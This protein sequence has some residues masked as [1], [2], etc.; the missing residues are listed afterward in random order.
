MV[1]SFSLYANTF[2]YLFPRCRVLTPLSFSL[3]KPPIFHLCAGKLNGGLGLC[4]FSGL[5]PLGGFF[6]GLSLKSTVRWG[7]VLPSSLR[8]E[9]TF[10]MWPVRFVWGSCRSH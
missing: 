5:G 3:S 7:F 2:F 4:S 10:T 1:H 6:M 9:G 8:G